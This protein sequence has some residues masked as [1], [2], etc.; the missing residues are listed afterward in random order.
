MNAAL[1]M[2]KEGERRD[3]PITGEKVVLG[4][5]PDCGI[6][7]P[8]ADVSRQHCEI[9]VTKAGL[10]VKDLGSSNGTY[11]NGKRIAESKLAPG[12]KLAI[13]PIIF[14]V[15]VNGF[16]AKITPFDLRPAPVVD[17]D[18]EEETIKP[19][20]EATKPAEA[21]PAGKGK[22]GV[23]GLDDEEGEVLDLD[24]FDIES[25]FDDDEEDDDLGPPKKK[26]K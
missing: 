22:L 9:A 2:F 15:Q 24:D 26:K 20:R 4:R 6:R 25:M 19:T 17:A 21:K 3:F 23:P 10:M 5:R 11:V 13:G 1:V 12:D 16:P 8:V 7:V 18:D 14:M